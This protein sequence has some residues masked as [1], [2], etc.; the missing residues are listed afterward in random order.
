MFL[1]RLIP[2]ATAVLALSGAV[3]AQQ[4]T[5]EVVMKTAIGS[6]KILRANDKQ[7]AFGKIEMN[8][9]GSLLIV[10]YKGKAPIQ[11]VGNLRK[12]YENKK[13]DRMLLVGQGK[14]VLDGE[15]R[16]IQW[17]GR[18]LTMTW[19]GFGICRLYG[20]FDKNGQTGTYVVKGDVLRYWG[21][22]GMQ[23]TLPA[24]T[25]PPAQKPKV[26]IGN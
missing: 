10:G 11:M 19:N 23:F 12:E 7:P 26:T 9:K 14:V 8:F 1:Q 4:Q 6:F 24:Y 16:A 21:S 15:F 3:F 20:E 13:T 5:G 2:T 22:G 17:F 18:D 25:A